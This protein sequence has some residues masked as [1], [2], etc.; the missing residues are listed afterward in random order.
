MGCC[1]F[2]F[3]DIVDP[4]RRLLCKTTPSSLHSSPF[5]SQFGFSLHCGTPT[6]SLGRMQTARC[7]CCF[8]SATSYH[9]SVIS[10]SIEVHIIPPRCHLPLH[11]RSDADK[12]NSLA[13]H[14][15]NAAHCVDMC[16]QPNPKHHSWRLNPDPRSGG[17]VILP[18]CLHPCFQLKLQTD[19]ASR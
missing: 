1:F 6:V 10:R 12:D 4:Q 18:L 5:F 16:T 15:A 13:S 11:K 19:A 2:V 7:L 14:P 8:F 17:R 3:F 9:I